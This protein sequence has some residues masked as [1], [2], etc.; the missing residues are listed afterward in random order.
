MSNYIFTRNAGILSSKTM[1][2]ENPTILASTSNNIIK[3]IVWCLPAG[4]TLSMKSM[5]QNTSCFSSEGDTIK[6]ADNNIASLETLYVEIDSWDNQSLNLL[7]LRTQV[8][9]STSASCSYIL[10]FL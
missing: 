5:P 8:S 7:D 10:Y 9:F 3:K 4:C 2:Q 6:L 1:L